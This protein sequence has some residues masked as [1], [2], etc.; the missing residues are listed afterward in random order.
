MTW[1]PRVETHERVFVSGDVDEKIVEG[2]IVEGK[3]VE[4]SEVEK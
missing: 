2:K 3:I 1:T 4:G